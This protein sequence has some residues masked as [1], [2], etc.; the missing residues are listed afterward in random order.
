MNQSNSQIN[1][2]VC[3][4]HHHHIHSNSFTFIH[5]FPFQIQILHCHLLCYIIQDAVDQEN[6][7]KKYF[8]F[9]EDKE[10]LLEEDKK[11]RKDKGK[12]KQIK[13]NTEPIKKQCRFVPISDMVAEDQ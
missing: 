8:H 7:K 10:S 6:T 3:F 4:V 11:N 9:K 2:N 12:I 1:S 5:S 13:Q